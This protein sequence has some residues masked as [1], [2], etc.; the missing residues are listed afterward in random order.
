MS[1]K[2]EVRQGLVTFI[3]I[4]VDDHET[5]TLHVYTSTDVADANRRSV[6]DVHERS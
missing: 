1:D 2:R 6:I 3:L 5:L 4:S